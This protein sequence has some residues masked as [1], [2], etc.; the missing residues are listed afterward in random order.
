LGTRINFPE[1]SFSGCPY[2]WIEK[3]KNKNKNVL[4]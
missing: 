3:T 1:E 4:I 2:S